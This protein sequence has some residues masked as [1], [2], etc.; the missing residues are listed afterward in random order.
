MPIEMNNREML[1]YPPGLDVN[2]RLYEYFKRRVVL[3][4]RHPI[5]EVAYVFNLADT[6]T[7]LIL[8]IG[9]KAVS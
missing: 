6:E 4:L 8:I 1:L 9:G 7:I 3:R 5:I 2:L